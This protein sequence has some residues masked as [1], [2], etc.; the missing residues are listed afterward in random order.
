MVERVHELSASVVGT[1]NPR[2]TQ[3]E[4]LQNYATIAKG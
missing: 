1:E 2:V 4:S 3:S